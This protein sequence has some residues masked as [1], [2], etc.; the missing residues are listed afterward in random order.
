MRAIRAL[1]LSWLRPTIT[2]SAPARAS[3]SAM[4]PHSSPVPPMTT[5]TLSCREKSE[6][7][8]SAEFE[9]G[10]R[11]VLYLHYPRESSVPNRPEQVEYAARR[12]CEAIPQHRARRRHRLYVGHGVS[13]VLF[14]R[15]S[16]AGTCDK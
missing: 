12:R 11:A 2:V 5:A 10:T 9:W 1:A 4:A 3:P 14:A 8:K 15:P 7:R 13:E 6:L 16:A